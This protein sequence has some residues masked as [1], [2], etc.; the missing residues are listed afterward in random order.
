MTNAL[1]DQPDSFMYIVCDAHSMPAGSKNSFNE[2][3][4]EL[5]EKGKTLKA[6]TIEGLA[7]KMNVDP[8]V[9]AETVRKYNKAVET[10]EDEFGK[11]LFDKKLN[12]APFYASPRVPTAHHTMGGVKINSDTQVIDTAGN[13]IPG[14]FA[15]GEVTGGIHGTNRLG[16]NALPDTIVYGRIAGEM[17][18]K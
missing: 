11:T 10:G 2:S 15:A 5:V 17:V 3:I 18:S 1:I 16:G 14:L 12:K 4:E 6:M 9:F 13:I 7:E 8:D